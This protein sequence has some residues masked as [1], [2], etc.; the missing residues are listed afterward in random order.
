[1]KMNR[2]PMIALFGPDGSGKST[3]AEIIM[4]R[5][6]EIGTQLI[7]MH[8]RPGF[9]PYRNLNCPGDEKKF[10][11]P[12][13]IKTRGGIKALMIFLYI[14]IDF[15]LG[16]YF[17]IRPLLRNDTVVIYERYYYDILVDQER[18][19]LLIPISIRTFANHFIPAPNTIILLD[20]SGKIL[21]ARKG[22][23][24]ITEI[25]RQRMMMIKYLHNF[26][27]FHIV[28]V[29]TSSPDEVADCVLRIA[30]QQWKNSTTYI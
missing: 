28:D 2:A 6:Q 22:E 11:N 16:Y 30:K 25:E 10:T 8:W 1:M 4:K 5:Y 23:L 18:Y 17:V 15:I 21:H 20:A 29:T 27:G 3:V 24:E 14:V 7:R 9:L 13:A 12:H 26:D 19:G